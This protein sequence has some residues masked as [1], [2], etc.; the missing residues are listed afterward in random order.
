M[1]LDEINELLEN[2][3]LYYYH[4]SN[5]LM[6]NSL[7]NVLP[8]IEVQ[9]KSIKELDLGADSFIFKGNFEELK[10]EIEPYISD[11]KIIEINPNT[12]IIDLLQEIGNK[13][14]LTNLIKLNCVIPDK[15][16]NQLISIVINHV[17]KTNNRFKIEQKS[18]N[19]LVCENIKQLNI[20]N[21]DFPV[22]HL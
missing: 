4:F 18:Q 13:E 2:E 3:M 19:I 21:I 6:Q 14:N 9:Y 7:L 17:Y 22:Y 12:S 20:S 15:I 5:I 16:K 11:L 8:D 1:D 10:K